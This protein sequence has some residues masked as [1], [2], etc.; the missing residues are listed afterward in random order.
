MR[1]RNTA[2]LALA[3]A[4]TGCGGPSAVVPEPGPDGES[5]AM[6]QIESSPTPA[7]IYVDRKYA[8]TTPLALPMAFDSRS[9]AI[10][11]VAEPMYP[12]QAR[13]RR[14]LSVPPL[15]YRLHF[16]MTNRSERSGND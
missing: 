9:E 5:V 8:G 12:A 1:F 16:F 2:A 14:V 13:Q 3:T 4:V 15:P 6:V 7:W 10:E 11:V